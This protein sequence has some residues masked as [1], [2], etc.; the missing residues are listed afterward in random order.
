M[1]NLQSAFTDETYENQR[2]EAE[3][4]FH[5]FF[6]AWLKAMKPVT[7]SDLVPEN[8]LRL[9]PEEIKLMGDL[10]ESCE[11]FVKAELSAFVSLLKRLGMP[12]SQA[13]KALDDHR[14][15]TIQE[16]HVQKWEYCLTKLFPV[17]RKDPKMSSFFWSQV[18][19]SVLDFVRLN[20]H[21]LLWLPPREHAPDLRTSQERV[22]LEDKL[23]SEQELLAVAEQQAR[24]SPQSSGAVEARKPAQLQVREEAPGAHPVAINQKEQSREGKQGHRRTLKEK[25]ANP[26]PHDTATVKEVRDYLDLSKSKVHRLLDEGPLKKLPQPKKGSKVS[27]LV[28]SIADYLKESA[29]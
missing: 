21:S 1:A 7:L 18:D 11:A 19:R 13:V 23:R 26:D 29:E 15:A 8:P 27:V 12:A 9:R 24:G 16:T 10:A 4:Q 25:L 3:R 14:K 5:A 20:L 28:T 2:G 17:L 22:Q 6:Q